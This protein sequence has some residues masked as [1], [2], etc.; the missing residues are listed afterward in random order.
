MIEQKSYFQHM[1]RRWDSICHSGISYRITHD[2][3]VVPIVHQ[4]VVLRPLQGR[5][6]FI[7]SMDHF[8]LQP[9][10]IAIRAVLQ[11]VRNHLHVWMHYVRLLQDRYHRIAETSREYQAGHLVLI[12]VV[13]HLMCAIAEAILEA[14]GHFGYFL[15]W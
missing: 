11:E 14:L 9:I 3:H 8:I 6:I 2:D 13:K 5:F 4:I 7:E 10:Q 15:P 1:R 12:Q